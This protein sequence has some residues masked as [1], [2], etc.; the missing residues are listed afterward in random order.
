M[1]EDIDLDEL[2]R[3][4]RASGWSNRD[5]DP[6]R[7]FDAEERAMAAKLLAPPP[8]PIPPTVRWCWYSNS[9]GRQW[10]IY[11]DD[12]LLRCRGF[13]EESLSRQLREFKAEGWTLERTADV[14]AVAA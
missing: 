14:L 6:M 1:T 13:S 3:G 10:R 8:E 5:K 7:G 11:G 9:L 2:E 12:G 4:L